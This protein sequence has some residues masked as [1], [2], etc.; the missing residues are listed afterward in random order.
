MKQK[1]DY[2]W[3]PKSSPEIRKHFEDITS[4]LSDIHKDLKKHYSFEHRIVGSYSRNLMTYD[5]KSNTGPDFDFNIYPNCDLDTIS[6]K[7]IKNLFRLSLNKYGSKYRYSFAEDSTRVLTIKII[8]TETSRVLFSVDF[9]F[10]YNYV[11]DDGYEQQLYIR[12]NKKHNS[13]SWEEQSDSIFNLPDD[14]DTIKEYGLWNEFKN[15]YLQLKN[16]NDIPEKKSRSILAE[17]VNCIFNEYQ[18]VFSEDAEELKPLSVT[19]LRIE[20]HSPKIQII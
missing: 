3:I 13:Y 11:D 9:A 8:D 7:E 6:A 20:T 16:A 2:R 12:F 10:V 17:A 18:D 15:K 19:G 4:L 14:L 5:V 1:H